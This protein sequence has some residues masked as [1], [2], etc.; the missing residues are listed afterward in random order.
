MKSTLACTLGLF[1]L[2]QVLNASQLVNPEDLV[3][4][5]PSVNSVSKVKRDVSLIEKEVIGLRILQG[6]TSEDYKLL[7]AKA[8]SFEDERKKKRDVCCTG[9]N[10]GGAPT[11]S[12][13]PP[14]PGAQIQPAVYQGQQG[15]AALQVLRAPSTEVQSSSGRS[16]HLNTYQNL[17]RGSIRTSIDE[18][19]LSYKL[20]TITQRRFFNINYN[21][22]LAL[23]YQTQ[24]KVQSNPQTRR[25][26]VTSP[27]SLSCGDVCDCSAI[28]FGT[29]GICTAKYCQCEPTTQ[30][31]VEFRCEKNQV[32]DPLTLKCDFA[33][34]TVLCS[35]LAEGAV[36]DLPGFGP[37]G[38]QGNAIN[39]GID[40]S[41]TRYDEQSQSG[42]GGVQGQYQGQSVGSGQS[43]QAYGQTVG[44][45]QTSSYGQSVQQVQVP[46][47][48][49]YSGSAQYSTGNQGAVDN[50]Q[51]RFDEQTQSG[52]GG[53]QGQAYSQ[54]VG[55]AQSQT[56]GKAVQQVQ[57]AAYGHSSGSEHQN[58]AH[59][60]PVAQ[61][62]STDHS[63]IQ[64]SADHQNQQNGAGVQQHSTAGHSTVGVTQ[65]QGGSTGQTYGQQSQYDQTATYAASVQQQ[66]SSGNAYG[67]A[68]GASTVG[69]AEVQQAY[70]HS[71][72]SV[73]QDGGAHQGATHQGTVNAHSDQS[74]TSG[75]DQQ[76]V[77]DGNQ[78]YYDQSNAQVTAAVQQGYGHDQGA[79]HS[80]GEATTSGTYAEQ[81]STV[82]QNAY[83]G[84]ATEG[85]TSG[86]QYYEQQS[87]QVAHHG[88]A[89]QVGTHQETLNAHNS[90]QA[91]VSGYDQQ[92][93]QQG[94]QQQYDNSGA[95]LTATYQGYDQGAQNS[96]GQDGSYNNAGYQGQVQSVG[97][98][99]QS[100]YATEQQQQQGV[101]QQS[102]QQGSTY[103]QQGHSGQ[104]TAQYGSAVDQ[105]SQQVVQEYDNSGHNA[106]VSHST[107]SQDSAVTS[108]AVDTTGQYYTQAVGPTAGQAHSAGQHSAYATQAQVGGTHAAGQHSAQGADSTVAHGHNTAHAV[109]TGAGQGY[110]VSQQQHSASSVSS[111]TQGTTV[112]GS[113]S[114][115]GQAQVGH[116]SPYVV[117]NGQLVQS[118]F[119]RTPVQ[120]VLPGDIQVVVLQPQSGLD[121][122]V[123]QTFQNPITSQ[124]Y[125]TQSV[126]GLVP[127]YS[128]VRQPGDAVVIDATGF[129]GVSQQ[130]IQQSGGLVGQTSDTTRL[131][132]PEGY[133]VGVVVVSSDGSS[134]TPL[135]QQTADS[136]VVHSSN[137]VGQSYG[138][139]GLSAQQQQ[140]GSRGIQ[141]SSQTNGAQLA[142]P[143]S[144]YLP[145]RF[146]F[147]RGNSVLSSSQLSQSSSQSFQSSYG[148]SVGSS[149]QSAAVTNG[150]SWVWKSTEPRPV[151]QLT[152]GHAS[153]N[154]IH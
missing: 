43:Q 16:H 1:A 25:A 78:Q 101:T 154:I 73:H 114:H 136:V 130:T 35:D 138:S 14:P 24:L 31:P 133:D 96:A 46:G 65:Q 139:S 100:G 44:Q 36:Y 6:A 103:A 17:I 34:N 23:A 55:S 21:Y 79:Q 105:V 129:G 77:Q 153:Y 62:H 57:G 108:G 82:E 132:A 4:I 2:V 95:Q 119:V 47:Y 40:Y 121:G 104:H 76:S 137:G 64:F 98:V 30:Q 3:Q 80:A 107:G 99:Q 52:A 68:Q 70:G 10:Q 87:V 147:A 45:V 32:F 12:Y 111:H 126:S 91:S 7:N 61:A 29:L 84:S 94:V 102:V 143:G 86:Q 122:T 33:S 88:S 67:A 28:G 125:S 11:Q 5:V 97:D 20:T 22:T 120:S 90:N 63:T 66:Q 144:A 145:P 50:S 27:N 146:D 128:A 152:A 39:V 110:Q 56:Y 49:Q 131:Q 15:S 60:E 92:T 8:N 51:I 123:I 83:G 58:T 109:G 74:A 135:V 140:S 19:K 148:R 149:Q 48:G 18:S 93:V 89:S 69:G 115:A 37:G 151:R 113:S 71:S 118:A 150:E 124:V 141:Y 142:E 112:H 134:R 81:V 85:L 38:G 127:T 42:V 13:A 54:S 41:Q 75:Y 59:Q 53:V 26:V 117:T 106:A 9:G 116:Q 72:G